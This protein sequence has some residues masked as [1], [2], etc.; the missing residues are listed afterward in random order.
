MFTIFV[1]DLNQKRNL[2]AVAADIMH[3]S[4]SVVYLIMY[5]ELNVVEV[6]CRRCKFKSKISMIISEWFFKSEWSARTVINWFHRDLKVYF[7]TKYIY[8]IRA[9]RFIYGRV[10]VSLKS[11]SNVWTGH[12]TSSLINDALNQ[13]QT[14]SKRKI[15]VTDTSIVFRSNHFFQQIQLPVI[16]EDR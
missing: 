6:I 13:I 5:I 15:N 1:Y 16:N 2:N 3:I 8:L 4:Y 9:G 7:D 14:W 11:G 12:V 10:W